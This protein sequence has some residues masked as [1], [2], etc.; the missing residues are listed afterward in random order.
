MLCKITVQNEKPIC[1]SNFQIHPL[2]LKYW[3]THFTPNSTYFT[4]GEIVV[5]D[6]VK[7]IESHLFNSNNILK[8]LS[9]MR[10][11]PMTTFRDITV[12]KSI[13]SFHQNNMKISRKFYHYINKILL[14][15]SSDFNLSKQQW[16]LFGIGGDFI[17]YFIGLKST[18]SSNFHLFPTGLASITNSDNIMQDANFNAKIYDISL[19][20]NLVN[21]SNKVEYPSFKTDIK[22]NIPTMIIVQ[23]A[24]INLVTIQYLLDNSEY[25]KYILI[26][27][28]HLDD[29]KKKTSKLHSRFS[30]MKF[31][32]FDNDSA[33]LLGVFLFVNKNLFKKQ[34]NKE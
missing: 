31:R 20:I 2:I 13:R 7:C 27:A 21:Y 12:W 22:L 15:I 17:S 6:K 10:R 9:D 4:N 34:K 1:H 19:D 8:S 26:I 23:M 18:Y 14:D 24:K 32:Y 16:K 28:C 11:I 33:G 5:V 30:I 25:I 29:Y 3:E